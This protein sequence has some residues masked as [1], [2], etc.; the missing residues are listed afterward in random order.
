MLL[1]LVV[2][3][4]EE[5]ISR[6]LLSSH[7]EHIWSFPVRLFC[8]RKGV[9]QREQPHA[10]DRPSRESIDVTEKASGFHALCEALNVHSR[11][12]DIHSQPREGHQRLPQAC[13]VKALQKLECTKHQ[14]PVFPFEQELLRLAVIFLQFQRQRTWVTGSI[15]PLGTVRLI[16][17]S[18]EAHKKDSK[19]LR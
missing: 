5:L 8:L 1:L 12:S 11:E 2:I 4:R 9:T 17:G 14:D 7:C 6:C 19:L 18:A 10:R 16:A 3:E 15:K 13:S